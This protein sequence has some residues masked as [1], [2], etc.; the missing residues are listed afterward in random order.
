MLCSS[1]ISGG[2]DKSGT[3][4][5]HD[6][7]PSAMVNTDTTGVGN[8]NARDSHPVVAKVLMR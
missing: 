2:R 4:V 7:D 3:V 8:P 5:I 6:L 1:V